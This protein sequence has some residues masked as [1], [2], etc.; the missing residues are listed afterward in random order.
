MV[1]T[2][3]RLCGQRDDAA[4]RLADAITALGEAWLQVHDISKRIEYALPPYLSPQNSATMLTLGT[5]ERA[6]T[7]E[8]WRVHPRTELMTGPPAVPGARR[9]IGIDPRK[10]QTPVDTFAS[11]DAY[12]VKTIAGEPVA[13]TVAAPMEA[14][15]EPATQAEEPGP[16][17]NAEVIM[18]ALRAAGPK[19][20]PLS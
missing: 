5:I 17:V 6:V 13:E 14:P 15:N 2:F 20:A 12:I 19:Q 9:P 7:A 8:L 16:V 11:A 3:K 4:K 18:A 10:M 1:A